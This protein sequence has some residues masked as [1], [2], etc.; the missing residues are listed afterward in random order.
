MAHKAWMGGAV[1]L[2]IVAGFG[3]AQFSIDCAANN[4]SIAVVL[5][6]VL[7]PTD[8]TK[9]ERVRNIQSFETAA[10]AAHARKCIHITSD[11]IPD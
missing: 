1:D 7:P 6:I 10:E 9:A 11:A 2:E 8:R 4:F 5:S 3:Q